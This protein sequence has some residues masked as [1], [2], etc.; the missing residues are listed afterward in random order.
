VL[1]DLIKFETARF[2][3]K[4]FRSPEPTPSYI[5]S[6]QDTKKVRPHTET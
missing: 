4:L 5:N 1:A 3:R 6:R 2:I